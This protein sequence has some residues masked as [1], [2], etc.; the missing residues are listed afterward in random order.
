MNIY[1]NFFIKTLILMLLVPALIV[2]TSLY[3]SNFFI[4][5][6]IIRYGESQ[7]IHKWLSQKK[8]AA[9]ILNEKGPKL[10]FL[11]G[12]NGHYGVNA[13]QIEK[14]TGIPTLNYASHAGLGTYIFYDAK[15]IL[16]KGDTVFLP[17]EYNFYCDKDEI[18]NLPTTLVEYTI[19]Y[20][21]AYYRQLPIKSKLKV[22]S[23]LIRINT[24][25]SLGKTVDENYTLSSRGDVLD[26]IGLLKDFAK[27]ATLEE[28]KVEKLS[29]KYKKWELYK[30]IQWCKAN[31]IK[32]YAFAPNIYHKPT[33]TKEEEESFDQIRKFYK[34]AG[35]EFVGNFEDG[36]FELKNFHNTTYH[37][38][39]KGR[40]IRS[41]YFIHKIKLIMKP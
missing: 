23:Y 20:D 2:M 15:R 34:L 36:F 14:A 17:L 8:T 3:L 32:V 5:K 27:T 4:G 16:R 22:L 21:N 6:G 1:K 9:K 33:A 30:F 28:I 41:N 18:N 19:A 39:E 37:L 11:S 26:A 10:V 38:N 13:E 35:V 24:L 40:E 7:M 31:D 25:T 29:D 12:S